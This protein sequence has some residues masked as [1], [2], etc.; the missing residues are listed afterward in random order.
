MAG[1]DNRVGR[2]LDLGAT[3]AWWGRKMNITKTIA[4]TL[5][6]LAMMSVSALAADIVTKAPKKVE[7]PTPPCDLAFGGGLQS[8]YNFRGI[9]Q[10]DRGP[11]V[12]GYAEPRC[13][14]TKDIQL[15]AGVWGW[16]TKLPTTPT[17]EFDLYGGI[18]PT[19]RPL[20][21]HFRFFFYLYPREVPQV[22][23]FPV[24][25]V[26]TPTPLPRLAPV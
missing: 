25:H 26:V 11:S 4:T 24:R 14:V 21:V 19:F 12:Y 13:N 5:A 8:D 2:V 1:D 22:S 20:P 3:T 9:S 16:S 17:G 15:Y 7:E 18:P 23:N 10:S 6:A